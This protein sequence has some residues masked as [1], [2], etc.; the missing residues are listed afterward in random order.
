MKNVIVV[1]HHHHHATLISSSPSCHNNV[2]C[3]ILQVHQHDKHTSSAS[4]LKDKYAI[5]YSGKACNGKQLTSAGNKLA[6][7]IFH[8]KQGIKQFRKNHIIQNWFFFVHIH[9]ND[10]KF[11]LVLHKHNSYIPTTNPKLVL[12]DKTCKISFYQ[13]YKNAIEIN[14]N[15]SELS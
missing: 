15:G 13:F 12:H 10:H 6:C 3:T 5:Q 4:I 1:P 7:R 11:Y 9:T 2:N 14:C 8:H